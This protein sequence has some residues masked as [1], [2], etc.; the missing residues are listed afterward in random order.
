M[1]VLNIG[2]D[3]QLLHNKKDKQ[4]NDIYQK[5]IQQND[6]YPDDNTMPIGR[7]PLWTIRFQMKSKNDISQNAIYEMT[8]EILKSIT[9]EQSRM[10]FG[11]FTFIEQH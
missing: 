4:K 11:R 10:T 3:C 5:C 8:M 1:K 2:I 7:I 9:I 6:T